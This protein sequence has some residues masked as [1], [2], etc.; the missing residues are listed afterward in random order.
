M[1]AFACAGKAGL[2]SRVSGGPCECCCTPATL[3]TLDLPPCPQVLKT[4][5]L[6]PWAAGAG[7]GFPSCIR[8]LYRQRTVLYLGAYQEGAK[9][10]EVSVAHSV[11][12]SAHSVPTLL[13]A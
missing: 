7:V 5:L 11:C 2:A 13:N 12:S 3:A 1:P 9:G 4:L 6:Q 8:L 10:Q